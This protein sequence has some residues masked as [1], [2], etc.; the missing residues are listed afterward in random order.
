MNEP[1]LEINVQQLANLQKNNQPFCLVDVREDEEVAAGKIAG[2]V[3]IPLAQLSTRAGELPKDTWIIMQC[4]SGGR[5]MKATQWA[6]ANGFE[7]VSNLAGG[8]T[9]WA[10]TIDPS[11]KVA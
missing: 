3:H 5:S 7:K 2:S 8:I 9:A 4:R 11:I 10:Q 6:R 1:P